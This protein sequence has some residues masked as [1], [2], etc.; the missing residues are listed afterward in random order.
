MK[1]RR[2]RGLRVGCT[3][4]IRRYRLEKAAQSSSTTLPR[5]SSPAHCLVLTRRSRRLVSEVTRV[6]SMGTRG[7]FKVQGTMSY[8]EIWP[9][10]PRVEALSLPILLTRD[11]CPEGEVVSVVRRFRDQ[12]SIS[13]RDVPGNS[14]S[15]T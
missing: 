1:K 11:A 9:R 13:R 15:C 14:P 10:L 3:S 4:H 5:V 7:R 6:L 8:G 12:G 2:G